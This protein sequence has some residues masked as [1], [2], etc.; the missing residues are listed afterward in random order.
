[1]VNIE[2]VLARTMSNTMD[3]SCLTQQLIDILQ[4]IIKSKT[5]PDFQGT[6]LST[7]DVLMV[8]LMGY[9]LLGNSLVLEEEY[10]RILKVA[11]AKAMMA[12]ARFNL[13]KCKGESTCYSSLGTTHLSTNA[14]C[15]SWSS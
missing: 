8:A 11:F 10:E 4:L 6:S 2:D 14:S 7:K 9:S 13:V 5:N 3:A 15:G 1:M 12:V